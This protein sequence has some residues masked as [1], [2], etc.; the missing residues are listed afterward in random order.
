M[1]TALIVSA[2]SGGGID[3]D[4]IV[5]RLH[6]HGVGVRVFE[7]EDIDRVA[8][9]A[10]DRIVVA[11]GD[12]SIGPVAELAGR[13]GALLAVV[14]VGTANNFA[15][16]KGIP[17][18]LDDACL[19]AA[20]GERSEPAELGRA[21]GVPFVNVASTGLAPVAAE[22]AARWKKALGPTAYTVGAASAALTASPMACEVMS[23]GR[24]EFAGE[25]WQVMIAATG[26]FGAGVVIEGTDP[27]D[28]LL[29]LVVFEPERRRRLLLRGWWISQ[30]RVASQPGA[31]RA[32]ASSFEVDV[33]AGTRFNVDGE[34]LELGPTRFSVD[35][36]PFRLLVPG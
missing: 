32:R 24:Q 14:P 11:G 30:G 35:P 2:G 34:V 3:P 15:A 1:A 29:D 8:A 6:G 25:S 28:G 18:D 5:G 21:G 20:R 4:Q 17:R 36:E 16:A 9:E 22:R 27:A 19:L 13:L 31:V 12:G 7:R 10:P 26:A 23:D 33:P